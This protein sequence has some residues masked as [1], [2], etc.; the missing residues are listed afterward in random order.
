MSGSARIDA[1]KDGVE[2]A[3]GGIDL[4]DGRLE[5]VHFGVLLCLRHRVLV[6]DPP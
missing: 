1:I 6:V 3:S 4:V 5:I 2:D